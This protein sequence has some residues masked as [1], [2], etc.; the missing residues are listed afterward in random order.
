MKSAGKRPL[1]RVT[2]CKSLLVSTPYSTAR[3][4][5]NKTRCPRITWMLAMIV[6]VGI[7]WSDI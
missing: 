5:S 2:A 3:S 6:S 1:F 4:V 7:I